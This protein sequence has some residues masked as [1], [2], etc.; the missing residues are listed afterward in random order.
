QSMNNN[1]SVLAFLQ[2]CLCLP[3]PSGTLHANFPLGTSFP[4]RIAHATRQ[5]FRGIGQF[6]YLHL[7]LQ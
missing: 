2:Q 4:E 5:F 3:V 1:Q 7:Y 6:R